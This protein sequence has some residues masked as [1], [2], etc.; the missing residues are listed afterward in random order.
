MLVGG[1][2]WKPRDDL[3]GEANE[4]KGEPLWF[5]LVFMNWLEVR[6]LRAG[7]G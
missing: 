3:P 4:N 2:S 5:A 1:K 7:P 6:R